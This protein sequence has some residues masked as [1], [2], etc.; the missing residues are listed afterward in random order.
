M[1]VKQRPSLPGALLPFSAF[2]TGRRPITCRRP[3]EIDILIATRRLTQQTAPPSHLAPSKLIGAL[4]AASHSTGHSRSSRLFDVLSDARHPPGHLVPS[5][6]ST[7]ARMTQ[8]SQETPK[9][10]EWD[11]QPRGFKR[12]GVHRVAGS[13]L[14]G[15]GDT[16]T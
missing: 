16:S 6:N 10:Q 4:L 5:C 13:A 11:K 7:V 14:S 9:N 12:L 3:L 1:M 8:S 2:L 15:Q